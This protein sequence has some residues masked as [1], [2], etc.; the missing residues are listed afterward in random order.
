M[1]KEK[2][3]YKILGIGHDSDKKEIKKVYRQLARKFHPDINPGNRLYEEKFKE[4]GEA[5][6]ILIDDNKRLQ[7]NRLR[8]ITSPKPQPEQVKKQASKGVFWAL[9]ENI[10]MRG[11]TFLAFLVLTRLLDKESLALTMFPI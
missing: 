4:L 9:T 2:D 7:Y 1:N 8:G 5:Y 11:I 3:Y 6:S 10:G